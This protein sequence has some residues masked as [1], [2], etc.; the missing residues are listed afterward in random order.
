ML[1]N[2]LCTECKKSFEID[3]FGQEV[4]MTSNAKNTGHHG[5]CEA[6]QKA[7]GKYPDLLT[8]GAPK[9]MKT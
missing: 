7:T 6:C 5:L 8:I 4:E 3:G 2:F 1:K 9:G